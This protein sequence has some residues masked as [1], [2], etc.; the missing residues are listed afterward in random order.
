MLT[1][2]VL[3]VFGPVSAGKTRFVMA[4]MVELGRQLAGDRREAGPGRGGER[5]AYFRRAAE[6]VERRE[7]TT[8]TDADRPPAAVTVRLRHDRAHRRSCTCST[9]PVSSSPTGSR[10]AACTTW[11]GSTGWS[12]CSTR[13]PSRRWRPGSAGAA[14]RPGSPQRSRRAAAGR[15]LPAHR[16]AAG[17]PPGH[18][19]RM[20]AGGGGGQGRPAA[21]AAA[22]RRA[23]RRPRT[24]T[25]SGTGWSSSGLDNTVTAAERDF[26]AVRYF[27][28]S[29][30]WSWTGTARARRPHRCAGCSPGR[31]PA[32]GSGA[33]RRPVNDRVPAALP[34]LPVRPGRAGARPARRAPS[35]TSSQP[36][37]LEEILRLLRMEVTACRRRGL[38]GR[39]MA[40]LR[41][42]RS[43]ARRSGRGDRR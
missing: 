6:L 20:A 10:T 23:R 29:A 42:R 35:G 43:A 9:R 2:V 15:G 3:P 17:R 32:A 38:T 30:R 13:S 24:R 1:D 37:N 5:A 18:A 39:A 4:G 19:A 8:K 7:Q 21:R 41:G 16:A 14:S 26:A 31:G 25:G 11:T 40:D 27:L 28:V 22:G 34:R 36:G 12:S 33:G